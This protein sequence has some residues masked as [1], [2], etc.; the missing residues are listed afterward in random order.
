MSQEFQEVAAQ[1]NFPFKCTEIY[2]KLEHAW[3]QFVDLN[4]RNSL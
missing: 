2:A 4:W 1:A 3:F